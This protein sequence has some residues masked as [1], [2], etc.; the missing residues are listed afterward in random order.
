[1]FIPGGGV[2]ESS[3]PFKLINLNLTFG[4]SAQVV[5]HTKCVIAGEVAIRRSVSFHMCM[6]CVMNVIQNRM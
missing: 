6:P 3:H 4:T 5:Y 1:M 2:Y